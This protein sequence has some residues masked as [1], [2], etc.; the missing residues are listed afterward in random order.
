MKFYTMTTSI[1][2]KQGFDTMKAMKKDLKLLH[3]LVNEF[4][5]VVYIQETP[6]DF[7]KFLDHFV[8]NK[9]RFFERRN[10]F[11][12]WV[13]SVFQREVISYDKWKAGQYSEEE[14]KRCFFGYEDDGSRNL[15][16]TA[17][18][19]QFREK[20]G[21]REEYLKRFEKVSHAQRDKRNLWVTII[22]HIVT[23]IVV[24][25]TAILNKP[26]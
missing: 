5:K 14:L 23:I 25:I 9:R 17:I 6:Q 12:Q 7:D 3:R 1:D 18:G 24:I 21:Y 8:Q 16:L 11:K 15:K 19:Q 10:E 2:K 20:D 13:K 26:K 4:Y 22:G